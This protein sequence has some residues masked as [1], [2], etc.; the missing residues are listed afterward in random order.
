MCTRGRFE[1]THGGVLNVHTGRGVCVCGGGGGEGGGWVQ[2]DTPTPT[3]CTPTTHT[4]THNEQTHNTQHRTR[5]V[6]SSKF[7]HV[8]LSLDPRGSP[9]KPL[10]LIHVQFEK[11]SRT[12]CP[13]VLQ[14]FAL[15]EEAL[16]QIDGSI[17]LSPSPPPLPPPPQQHTTRN[18]QR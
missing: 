8:G 2:R 9:K 12:T 18:T 13:R 5:K 4:H 11:R 16:R 10:D 6:A 3:H 17:S 14:S 7:D 15:L 1:R